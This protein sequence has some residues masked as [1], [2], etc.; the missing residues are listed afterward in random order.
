M[1]FKPM[2]ISSWKGLRSWVSGECLVLVS[3]ILCISGIFSLATG[4]L[5]S[6]RGSSVL[7]WHILFLQPVFFP[8][9][10]SLVFLPSTSLLL[11]SCVLASFPISA[12][13]PEQVFWAAA[14]A[15]VRLF[16]QRLVVQVP[17]T[18]AQ[19]L[20]PSVFLAGAFEHLQGWCRLTG[21]NQGAGRT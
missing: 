15:P 8:L 21:P 19:Q 10:F 11:C 5:I 18:T 16:P 9:H 1:S 3:L 7:L 20:C 13:F 17:F 6:L 14:L 12:V 4:I 2:L